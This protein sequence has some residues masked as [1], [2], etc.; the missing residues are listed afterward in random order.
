MKS[1]HTGQCNGTLRGH[2]DEVLDVAFDST[3]QYLVSVSADSTG[4]IYNANTHQ[5]VTKL[6]GHEGEISKV[7][8]TCVLQ[9]LYY[10]YYYIGL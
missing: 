5:L 8:L 10:V 9:A 6:N 2:S 1:Y 3:G 7:R 4:R